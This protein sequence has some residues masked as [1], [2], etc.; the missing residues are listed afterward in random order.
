[1]V[2]PVAILGMGDLPP[3]N[4]ESLFHGALFSPLRNWV[5]ELTIPYYLEISWE[6]IDPSS[7][8]SSKFQGA[9]F[10]VFVPRV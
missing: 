4:R 1:M 3:F 8:F 6:L 7:T 5:D 2:K 10:V 9:F